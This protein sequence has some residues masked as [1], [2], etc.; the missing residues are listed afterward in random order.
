M[1]R[2]ES[3][4]QAMRGKTGFLLKRKKRRSY[5]PVILDEKKGNWAWL[6]AN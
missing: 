5:R 1:G 2:G 6:D 3:R 4:N